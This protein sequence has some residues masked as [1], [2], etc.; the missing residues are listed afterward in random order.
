ME[1]LWLAKKTLREKGFSLTI[2][3]AG[4][5]ILSIGEPGIGALVKAIDDLGQELN[6]ASIADMI[7]GK[8]GAMLCL[9]AKVKRVWAETISESGIQTFQK[10]GI[11]FAFGLSVP[12]ILNRNRNDLCPFE[13]MTIQSGTPD[14]AYKRIREFLQTKRKKNR[15]NVFN[16]CDLNH[17]IMFDLVTIGHFTIDHVILPNRIISKPSLGGPA[18]YVS[19]A[20]SNLGKNAS[21]ISKVGDDFCDRFISWL[22]SNRVDLSGLKHIE[23]ALTTRFILRYQEEKRIIQ[24]KNLA[25]PIHS[26]D[27]PNSLTSKIIHIAP[28]ADEINK[29]VIQKLRRR[30]VFLSLDP[31]GFLR[32]IDADGK[33][34]LK[35]WT[36]PIVLKNIN[37]YKSSINEI[38]ALTSM[39][40]LHSAIERVYEWGPEIVIVTK[41]RKGSIL[42]YD[43][44][45]Y[46]VPS[47][48]TEVLLDPTG[49][50]D[51]YIGAFLAEYIE[52]KDPLWCACVGSA[53]ASVVLERIGSRAFE[54][55]EVHRRATEIFETYARVPR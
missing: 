54:K 11:E 43:D 39:N 4:R 48:N 44:S 21:V 46:E 42:F 38:R 28:V 19:I 9:Y 20:A 50:G 34:N 25:P 16:L 36:D 52:K 51:S 24:L 17:R 5:V 47:C 10:A 55:K 1:D 37:L 14:E 18:T 32:R 7:V 2:V 40:N 23:G 31:Q 27:I 12:R 13:K 45:F 49:A 35:S 8:A 33:V 41:G 22:N 30:S 6:G 3:K 26:D 15:Y 53:A 29:E